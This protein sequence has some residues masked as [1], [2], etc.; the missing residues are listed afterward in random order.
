MALDMDAEED[1]D[2]EEFL[3]LQQLNA[4][5][6][7]LHLSQPYWQYERFD[8][9]AM[10]YSECLVE[11]RFSKN[12]IYQLVHVFRFPESFTCYNGTVVDAVEALC[13]ALKRYAY[14]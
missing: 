5:R 14:P 1:V 6:R 8:L 11:F 2:G 13:I 4:P 10:E 12:E 3:L 9:E 7:N